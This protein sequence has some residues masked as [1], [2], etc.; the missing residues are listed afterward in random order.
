MRCV[1][2]ECQMNERNCFRVAPHCLVEA[3][4]AATAHRGCPPEFANKDF[5]AESS[6]ESSGASSQFL[7]ADRD[8]AFR[9]PF[10]GARH[11][12]GVGAD[13]ALDPAGQA[14]RSAAWKVG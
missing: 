11:H 13:R 4:E 12:S 2:V 7:A 14:R 9:T 1:L 6:S 10:H 5:S 3:I 8:C